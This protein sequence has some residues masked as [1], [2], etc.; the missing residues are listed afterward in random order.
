M[1]AWQR[2]QKLGYKAFENYIKANN[3]LD[4]FVATYKNSR[5]APKNEYTNLQ[6][7]TDRILAEDF[8][9]PIDLP[10]YDRSAMDGYAI[11]AVDIKGASADHPVVLQVVG[12]AYAG[13]AP[14]GKISSGQ[15]IAIAT[16]ARIPIDADA[17]VMVEDTSSEDKNK[18]V[19]IYKEIET[20]KNIAKIGE[21]LKQG[22]L[23]LERGTWL[24][25]QDIGVMASTGINT[26]QVY[27]RPKIAVFST[28]NE[29]VEPGVKLSSEG[30]LYESNRYMLAAMITKYGGEAVSLGICKD[31]KPHIQ[32]TLKKALEYDAVVI[33]GGSSVGEKDFVPQVINAAGTPGIIVHGIAMRPGSPTALGIVEGKP[34]IST[35]GYPVACFFAFY[36]FGKPLLHEMLKTKGLPEAKVT[37]KM[38][39]EIKLRKGMRSFVRVKLTVAQNQEGYIAEP[40]STTGASVLSTLT[41]PEGLIVVDEKEH[42]AKDAPVEVVLLKPI[43]ST[44]PYG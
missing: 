22:Q 17:V 14:L 12:R 10:P 35:P 24:R 4:L 40:V 34:V 3:A 18:T 33:S 13:D 32:A 31:D 2:D 9:S 15:A 37:A 38:A 7:A 29:L 39:S 11:R 8:L 36:T 30:V 27:C 16:G 1:S 25:P 44:K 26:I 5:S 20:G 41:G 23:L 28:G 42:L 6:E 19:N 43:G 21:D